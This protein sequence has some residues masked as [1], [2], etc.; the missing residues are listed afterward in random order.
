[1]S[2]EGDERYFEEE[3]T[4]G[5]SFDARLLGETLKTMPVRSPIT[6]GPED[7]VTVAVRAMQ[8][9]RRGC[10]LVTSDGTAESPLLGIFSDRDV[11]H[12][13]VDQGRN[14]AV[15]P[16]RE[17]M[18]PD[19][20]C[21][22]A[23]ASIAWVLNKMAIGGFRHVP[24]VDVQRHPQFVVSVRDVVD[25]LVEFFPREILNLPP[26]FGRPCSD[27]REGA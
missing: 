25:F 22:P 3:A 8:A 4:P 12:R 23:D 16:L 9:C 2:I 26:E 17:V 18:T 27:R 6:F 21:L 5:R 15:L 20:E 7:G 11:L 1:M 13:V 14:P 24:V 10:V 19:P